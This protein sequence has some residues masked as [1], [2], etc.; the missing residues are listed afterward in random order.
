MRHRK[1][2]VR[3]GRSGAHRA[4]LM[5]S[6]VCNLIEEQRIRTTLAKAKAGRRLAEK[7]VT[8][9][10][11]GGLAARRRAVAVLHRKPQ[12]KKLFDVIAPQFTDRPGGYTRMARLGRRASDS[13]EMALLEWVSLAPV[14]KKRKPRV[15]AAETAAADATKG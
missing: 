14:D 6:L 11:R 12:V 15:K 10:K 8:L 3:L 7:M 2:T 1:D 4:A 5:A 9:A 13:S